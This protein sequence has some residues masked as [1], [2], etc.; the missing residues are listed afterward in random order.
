MATLSP[1]AQRQGDLVVINA[2]SGF[3]LGMVIGGP[4]LR[5][6]HRRAGEV[7]HLAARLNATEH[8]EVDIVEAS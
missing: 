6:H 1:E 5:G 3:A 4:L 2:G 7:G 8:G